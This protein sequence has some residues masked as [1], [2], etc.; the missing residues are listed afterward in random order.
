MLRQNKLK[1][2]KCLTHRSNAWG[3]QISADNWALLWSKGRHMLLFWAF[4]VSWMRQHSW[5]WSAS[6]QTLVGIGRHSLDI[7]KAVCSGGTLGKLTGDSAGGPWRPGSWHWHKGTAEVHTEQLT[8]TV[9]LHRTHL[10]RPV[11]HVPAI[12]KG[13]RGETEVKVVKCSRKQRQRIAL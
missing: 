5:L 11:R 13:N 3:I 2:Q 9:L 7:G 6:V 12:L 10:W 1:Q 4:A 8:D